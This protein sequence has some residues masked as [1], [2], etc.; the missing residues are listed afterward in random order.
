MWEYALKLCKELIQH[1][2]LETYDYTK[3]AKYHKYCETFYDKIMKQEIVSERQP[4][5]FRVWFIG[6]VLWVLLLS[7][8]DF[9]LDFFV[10]NILPQ[11]LLTGRLV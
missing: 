1:H 9:I 11:T 3:A 6:M 10:D 8:R 2:E 7:K 4:E 5:Y